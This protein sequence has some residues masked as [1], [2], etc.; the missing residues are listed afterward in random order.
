MSARSGAAA[1][2][3]MLCCAQAASSGWK[4]AKGT[5]YPAFTSCVSSNLCMF[6]SCRRGGEWSFE[7][8]SVEN[9]LSAG[10]TLSLAAAG[11][12]IMLIVPPRTNND[13]YRWPLRQ[14][15][16][17]ILSS[18]SKAVIVFDDRTKWPVKTEGYVLAKSDLSR[19]CKV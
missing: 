11:R 4:P 19:R 15:I 7:I 16:D 8:Y 2:L 1:L 9:G 5:P 10:D 17:E 14:D 13:L 12:Q 3:S 18:G 6:V